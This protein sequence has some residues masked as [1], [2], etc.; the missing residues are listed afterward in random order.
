MKS[1]V[2]W[3][4]EIIQGSKPVTNPK[5]NIQQQA[6]PDSDLPTFQAMFASHPAIMLLIEPETDFILEA[7]SAAVKFYGYPKKN[8]AGCRF[9][10]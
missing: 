8:C 4:N 10:K 3:N 9:L 1:G 2:L 7:N 5:N 6:Q